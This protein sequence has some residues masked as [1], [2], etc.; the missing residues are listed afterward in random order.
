MDEGGIGGL[1]GAHQIAHPIDIDGLATGRIR[2]GAVDVGIG[3]AVDDRG[4]LAG[5]AEGPDCGCVADIQR[6]DPVGGQGVGKEEPLLPFREQ[7]Q[8]RAELAASACNEDPGH[9]TVWL[10]DSAD[11][12]NEGALESFSERITEAGSTPQSMPTSGSSQRNEPSLAGA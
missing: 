7:P 6:L 11:S 10:S 1:C 12:R 9:Y 8:F 3:G 2:L 4:D 5:T